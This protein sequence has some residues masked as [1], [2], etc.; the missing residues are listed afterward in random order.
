[1]KTI[2]TR[3]GTTVIVDDD[4]YEW[5]SRRTLGLD[6]KGYV[7]FW[8]ET[9][10]RQVHKKL[11]R[12]IMGEPVGYQVDHINRNKLDNRRE[13]LRLCSNLD[14]SKNRGV[15][16]THNGKPKTSLFKGLCWNKDRRKWQSGI[17]V[18]GKRQHLG[19][20]VNEM[21]AAIAYDTAALKHFGEFAHINFPKGKVG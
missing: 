12:V 3:N 20:F 21:D 9:K 19:L 11:H 8:Y 7:R 6:N 14:N 5:A 15:H 16:R 18:D 17:Q 1:M 4:V 2:N 10:E 13:N